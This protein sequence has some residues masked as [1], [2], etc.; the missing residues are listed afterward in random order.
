MEGDGDTGCPVAQALSRVPLR[1]TVT[2][3]R[4][5]G[6]H[7]RL[8]SQGKRSLPHPPPWELSLVFLY[9]RKERKAQMGAQDQPQS[10][11]S[12]PLEAEPV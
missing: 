2:R 7:S 10:S 12:Q 1:N 5:Q 11:G 3:L 6:K 4:S 9:K 8:R